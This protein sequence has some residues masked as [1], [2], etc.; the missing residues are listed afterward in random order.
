MLLDVA[1]GILN[2]PESILSVLFG[3]TV[4]NISS[5]SSNMDARQVILKKIKKKKKKKKNK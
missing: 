3:K 1:L 5:P 2:N 4:P